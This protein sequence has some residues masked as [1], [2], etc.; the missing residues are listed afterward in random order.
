[1]PDD[2]SKIEK[3]ESMAAQTASPLEAEVARLLLERLEGYRARA[4]SLRVLRREDVLAHPDRTDRRFVVWYTDNW[5]RR[6]S[7]NAD[8]LISNFE[9]LNLSFEELNRCVQAA[10]AGIAKLQSVRL[11]VETD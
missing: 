5:G 9:Q 3:L 4:E 2:R 11:E 7:V 1:M 10:V 6:V 8:E